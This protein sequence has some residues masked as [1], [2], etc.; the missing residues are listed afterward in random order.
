[1]RILYHHRIASRDGQATHVEAMIQALGELGHEVRE[2]GPDVYRRDSG[3]GGSPGW[4]GAVKAVLP[5]PAYHLAEM[6][7]TAPAYAR[8][9][10]E[11]LAFRPDAI[12][13]R[14]ALRN[15]AGVWAARRHRVPLLLEV[16]APYA[17]AERQKGGPSAVAPLSD[18]CEHYTWRQASRVLPV[19]GVLATM[20]E[21][22]GVP[23]HR[24]RVIGNAIDPAAFAQVPTQ[25]E[26]KQVLG[27]GGRVVVGFTGFVNEWDRLD[28]VITWLAGYAGRER[29]HLLVVGDGPVRPALELQ[30]RQAGVPDL[31]TFTGIVP[32]GEVPRLAASF[33]VALQMALVPY[34]SPLCLFE[35]MALGKAIVAPDQ[36]NHHEILRVGVDALLYDPD[37]PA[38]LER[39][40]EVAVADPD[41]RARLGV[42]ARE[43][44]RQRGY[45][46]AANAQRVVDEVV[47]LRGRS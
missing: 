14:Y 47:A 45:T 31:V 43:T 41:L 18:W 22:A 26:A 29:V 12:Y 23:A 42:E 13:E 11:I 46:W 16:N 32:R 1:M 19:T 9:A 3:E 20:I 36:P 6:G 40:I 34:A 24:I 25:E 35:Y 7:Y 39:K 27:L 38:D 5:R 37:D 15:L 33:D 17:V 2:C 4:V 44:L 28:R 30:A 10:R 8:L 21:A